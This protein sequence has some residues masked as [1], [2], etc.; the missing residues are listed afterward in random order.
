VPASERV[1]REQV[2]EALAQRTEP[3][4]DREDK[5]LLVRRLR[6]GHLATQNGDPWRSTS[7]SRSFERDDLHA[8]SRSRR[9]WRMASVIRRTV[10]GPVWLPVVCRSSGSPRIVSSSSSRWHSSWPSGGG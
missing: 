3:L 2:G 4:E 8:R 5:P 9:T 7:S 6:M 1:G 10:T